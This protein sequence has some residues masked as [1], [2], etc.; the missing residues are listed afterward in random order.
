MTV[1]IVTLEIGGLKLLHDQL[2]TLKTCLSVNAS[3]TYLTTEVAGVDY[4]VT[5]AKTFYL[6][7]IKV[8]SKAAEVT[9]TIAQCDAADSATGEI[10]KVTLQSLSVANV[11]DVPFTNLP[12]FAATK[13]VNV[14]WDTT[15]NAP[16]V[17][18]YGYEE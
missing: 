10:V 18:L 1:K 4:Q 12:S 3:T 9:V 15:T 6:V 7:G 13:Y 5:A 14:K 8:I 17:I 2:A 16:R 11:Y